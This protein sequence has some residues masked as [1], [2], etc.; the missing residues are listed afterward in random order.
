MEFLEEYGEHRRGFF[1]V[2]FCDPKASS[3][4]SRQ[5]SIPD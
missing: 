3:P 5:G 2:E 4:T 1:F